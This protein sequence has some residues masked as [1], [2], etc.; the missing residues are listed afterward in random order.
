MMLISFSE[1]I[2][3]L[4][5][6]DVAGDDQRELDSIK[7]VVVPHPPYDG[8]FALPRSATKCYRFGCSGSFVAPNSVPTGQKESREEVTSGKEA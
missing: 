6:P 2:A 3:R 5:E 1:E 7:A 8:P 4:T